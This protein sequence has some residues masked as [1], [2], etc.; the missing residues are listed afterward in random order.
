[1]DFDAIEEISLEQF[2][3]KEPVYYNLTFTFESFSHKDLTIKFAFEAYFYLVL[4]NLMGITSI[5]F[6]GIFACFHRV[7]ARPAR[8]EGKEAKIAPCKFFTYYWLTVPQAFY[9]SMYAIIPVFIVDGLI[10]VFITGTVIEYD[11]S[12]F[13]CDSIKREECILT[14]F[15]LMK[16]DSD[17]ISVN[18]T[19]LRTGRC[20]TALFVTGAYLLYVGL[21][22]LI[23]DT[24]DKR[25]I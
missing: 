23:P 7:V 25:K 22:V 15:D 2:E 16:D 14:F 19:D 21:L 4:Y 5:I 9:G 24:S 18:Y 12:I 20:G 17:K 3:G 10:A 6:M 1:M 8:N 13:E 11:F